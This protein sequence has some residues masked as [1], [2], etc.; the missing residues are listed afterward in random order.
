[1][2]FEPPPLKK[3]GVIGIVSPARTPHPE[4]IKKGR[5]TL[6][7]RGYRVVVHPQNYLKAGQLAGSDR[8]RADAVMDMFSNP[9]INAIMCARG[10]T[11]AI[12]I[13]DL[14]DYKI[15]KRNPKPFVGFSDITCLLQ[16][17]RVKTGMV[18]YHGPMLWNFAHSHDARTEG[19]LFTQIGA[20]KKPKLKVKATCVRP[21][22]AEGKLV[23]G[24]LSRIEILTGTDY[25]IPSKNTI[26]FIEDV[27]EALYKLDIKLQ[28]LRLAGKLKGLRGV[29]VGEMVDISDGETGHDKRTGNPY[30]RSLKQILLDN[31]PPNIPLCMGFPCGHGKYITTF[32]VG[33][34]VSVNVRKNSVDLLFS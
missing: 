1:M 17:I 16:A 11:G 33:A 30:G 15:I 9:S 6:E 25:D 8:E 4:W 26:L 2:A 21:G 32:P 12:R 29:I 28:H 10:G 14:L 13:V 23:G 24:N 20:G 22:K 3:G 18:T 27:D 31:L 34:R 7:K 5:A 19:D